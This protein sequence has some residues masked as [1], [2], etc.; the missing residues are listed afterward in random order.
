MHNGGTPVPRPSPRPYPCGKGGGIGGAKGDTTGAGTGGYSNAASF[1]YLPAKKY[2]EYAG[3]N[4]IA[5]TDTSDTTYKIN[6]TTRIP[7]ITAKL[8]V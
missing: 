8:T 6:P 3:K 2:S 4:T 5:G 1:G 7:T